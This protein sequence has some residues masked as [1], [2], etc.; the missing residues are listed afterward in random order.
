MKAKTWTHTV[1]A[2]FA[3]VLSFSAVGNLI[4]GYE[5]PVDTLWKIALWCALFSIGSAMV[6]RLRYGGKIILILGFLG[7]IFL[8]KRESVWMQAQTISYMITSHYHRVYGWPILGNPAAGEVSVPLILWTALVS[9]GVNWHIC[10]RKHWTFAFLPTVLPLVLCLMTI[11]KVPYAIYLYLTILGLSILLITDWTRCHSPNQGMKLVFRITVPVSIFLAILFLLNP[12]GRYVNRAGSLQKEVIAWFEEFQDTAENIVS[13]SPLETGAVEKLNLKYVG[14]KNNISH[15]VMR[16]SSPI[17][18]TLYLRGRDYDKYTGTGWEATSDRKEAFTTGGA[19]AGEISI[20]TYGVRSVLY[21]PYYVTE[22][23]ELV[24]GAWENDQNYQR[25]SFYLSA[26]GS[27]S[28]STPAARYR[29]LPDETRQWATELVSDITDGV[30]SD[31]E[32]LRRIQNYVRSSAVYDLSTLRMDSGYADFAQ[33]F[34]EESE[35]GY[36]VHFAT[37][38]TVL[39]RAAGI[40]SRYVEGY[41]VTCTA[42]E[43]KVVSSRDAHAWAEY[44]D[45]DYGIWRVLEATPADPEEEETAPEDSI[46]ETETVPDDTQEETEAPGTESSEGTSMPT[47]PNAGRNE[48]PGA[49]DNSS[50]N[51]PE[52]DKEKKPFKIPG[53]I[54][55]VFKC[56][57][58]ATCIPLQAYVRIY[59]KRMLWN[60]GRPNTRTIE[61]WHQTR[62]LAKLLKQAYPEELDSMAQKA[63]FSQYR[64]QPEELQQYENYRLSLMDQVHSMPWFQ[65]IIFKWLLAVD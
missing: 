27:R 54:K 34:L 20:V 14:P 39:L 24:D 13:G 61:R 3:L 53:W 28:T 10:R 32:K 40:P 55:T 2:L 63:K 51:I 64:I 26:A 49:P 60:N 9:T 58:Y 23:V 65:R 46:P 41:M 31:R 8:W 33:W 16:V 22:D 21:V 30:A 6:L 62:S 12:E 45:S 59:R 5:L 43:D 18:G 57:L 17:N 38:A 56:L 7:L 36:C 50:G 25:Y 19:S 47:K 1:S 4:T 42:G 29:E 15:S 37:S 11:D 44:Y 35:T 52:K 48:D